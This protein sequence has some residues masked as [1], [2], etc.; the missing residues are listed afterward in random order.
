ME[1]PPLQ[2]EDAPQEDQQN[3]EQKREIPRAGLLVGAQR[4][5][6]S[7][8]KNQNPQK[9]QKTAADSIYGH[10]SV[11]LAFLS[12]NSFCKPVR[13]IPVMGIGD[14]V[15]PNRLQVLPHQ[16]LRRPRIAILQGPD[17]PACCVQ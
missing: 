14:Q 1:R 10:I 5:N 2:H 4:K 12:R 13:L 15:R 16:P 6:P 9:H 17:D 3:G 7:L 11:F 8:P